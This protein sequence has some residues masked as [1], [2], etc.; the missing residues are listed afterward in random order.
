MLLKKLHSL[1]LFALLAVAAASLA[2]GVGHA[3]TS[4]RRRMNTAVVQTM[5]SPLLAKYQVHE[6]LA[7][8]DE[9]LKDTLEAIQTKIVEEFRSLE[10]VFEE[11]VSSTVGNR[12]LTTVPTNHSK[13][14]AVLTNQTCNDGVSGDSCRAQKKLRALKETVYQKRLAQREKKKEIL[15]RAESLLGKST[16]Q[17]YEN[18]DALLGLTEV[19]MESIVST[20]AA[21]KKWTK[22]AL[23]RNL[24]SF[25][26]VLST[27][28][29]LAN[30]VDS[31]KN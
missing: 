5:L 17:K 26:K 31:L 14:N 11:R 9:G 4:G 15:G 2:V 1:G 16:P 3:S 12:T 21:V 22:D 19:S 18:A 24:L 27:D 29:K 25:A 23:L 8:T 10:S 20:R 13:V 6:P 28:E 7:Y 30:F